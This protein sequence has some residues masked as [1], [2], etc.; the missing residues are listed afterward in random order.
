[1]INEIVA[2]HRPSI[3]VRDT[4][5]RRERHLRLPRAYA[6]AS[7]VVLTIAVA[8]IA[9]A[10]PSRWTPAQNV[11]ISVLQGS[12][13]GAHIAT[14]AGGLLVGPFGTPFEIAALGFDIGLKNTPASLVPPGSFSVNPNRPAAGSSGPYNCVY[15]FGTTVPKSNLIPGGI[16]DGFG[17]V[18]YIPFNPVDNV[19]SNLGQPA[20]YHPQADVTITVENPHLGVGLP[21][22]PEGRHTLN[23]SAATSMNYIMDVG[24]PGVLIPIFWYSENQLEAKLAAKAVAK[25]GKESAEL[26]AKKTAEN[27]FRVVSVAEEAG[28]IAADVSNVAS[29]NDWYQNTSVVTAINAGTQTLTVWDTH[30]PYFRD[31]QSAATGVT[32]QNIELEATDFGGVRFGR[33]ADALRARFEPVDDCGKQFQTWTDTQSSTLL[34]VG[35]GPTDVT[36]KAKEVDGGPY[37][38]SIQPASNQTR[39]GENFVTSLVQH[40][41]VVDTQ[42]PILVPP[43]GFARYSATSVDLNATPFPLGRPLVV[44][45]A[46]PAPVVTHTGPAVLD[47][48]HR[49]VIDWTATDDSGNST[50][51][52]PGNPSQYTQIVTIKSPG[53]NTP[54]TAAP[55]SAATLT[56]KAVEI[57]LTG[58]DSDLLDGR[59]DPLAFEIKDYP[60]HGQFEAPLLP[61]FIEDFRLSPVG[62]RENEQT[63]T[64]TSPLGDLAD[65]FRLEDPA[66]HGTFLTNQICNAAPG[67]ANEAAFNHTIPVNFVYQPTYIYVDDDGYYYIRDKFWVCGEPPNDGDYRTTM[68]PIPRISKWNAAGELVAMQPL[69]QTLSPLYDDPW[70]SGYPTDDFSVDH[71]GRIW[72]ELG[73]F[74]TAGGRIA[75]YYSF[76]KDLGDEQFHGTLGSNEQQLT[77]GEWL[78]KLA[79]DAQFDL[80]YELRRNPDC[81]F[82]SCEP[83][84]AQHSL[85]VRRASTAANLSTEDGVL[86]RI[87]LYGLGDKNTLGDLD[88]GAYDVKVDSHGNVYILDALKN[89]IHKYTATTR[90]DA[91]VWELGQEVGWMG[92]CSANLLDPNGVPYNG[93]DEAAQTSRGYQCTDA[94]C[95][96]AADTSGAGPG[97][98]NNP[99]SIEIDPR[100]VLYVA[101]TGNSR[102]QRFGPDGTFAGEAKSTGTGVNQGADPGF[103]LGNMGQ[104]K[105]LAV[106]SSAFYVMEPDPQNGDNFVHVFK[107]MP[108]YDITDASAK[109]K[110]VSQFDF[111]GTDGFTYVTNDGIDRSAP[112]AVSVDVSRAFRPPERLRSQCFADDTLTSEIPCTLAE[113]ADIVIRFSAYDPDGFISTGGLDSLTFNLLDQPQHGTLTLLTSED[114][115]AVY[116]YTPAADYN[117][118]DQLSFEASDGVDTSADN[119]SVALTIEPRPDPVAIEFPDN[120]V[121]ARGFQHTFT[122][123]FKDVDADDVSKPQALSVSWGDGVTAATPTWAGSGR[124]DTNGREIDPQQDLGIASG[125]IVGSHTYASTG[126]YA[127][128]ITMANAPAENLPDTVASTNVQVIEATVVG[129]SLAAPADPVAPD[130]PF[131]LQIDVTNYVPQGWAGLTAAGTQLAI[132]VPDGLTL[133]SLDNRCT[134]GQPIV[135]TIGDLTPGQ[136][137]TLTF[138]A[139][140]TLAAARADSDYMLKL[141]LTDAGPHAQDKNIGTATVSIADQDQDGVIDVDDAF[142]NDPRYS[143]DTDGDG[144]PDD[145]ETAHGFDPNTADNTALDSDGDGFTLAEEFANGSAPLLAEVQ[146]HKQGQKLESPTTGTNDR[147]GQALAGGDFNHDGYADT[148]IGA[149]LSDGPGAVFISYGSADGANPSLTSSKISAP[150]GVTFFGRALAVGDFDGNGYADLAIA[151]NEAI[152]I[153]LNNGQILETPDVVL[154]GAS[155]DSLGVFMT[156]GDLDGDG[157]ADL[158]DMAAQASGTGIVKIYLSSRGFAAAPLLFSSATATAADSAVIADIDGDQ[159]NDLVVGLSSIGTVN[160]FLARDNDWAN[161]ST[162]TT[163]FVLASP[164]P[165]TFGYSL[166]SGGDIGGDGIDDLVVGAYSGAGRIYVYDSTT[167]YWQTPN[168]GDTSTVPPSQTVNGLEDG[169]QPGDTFAGQFGVRIA[170]GKLD[171]DGYAD[172]VVGGS[173]AG[174]TDQGEVQIFHGGPT[175]LEPTPQI[176]PGATPYHMLGYFV[177]IPGDINGDGFDDVAAGAPDI[178]VSQNPAPTGGYVQTFYHAFVAADPNQDPDDD[179]VATAVDNCPSD[180]E[181]E[182]VRH[183]RR[184]RRRRVRL[185]RGRRRLRQRSRQLPARRIQRSDQQRR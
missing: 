148:V 163:S 162:L 109:V 20:V 93:C 139:L 124:L 31:T 46:D 32:Q 123:N 8:Q 47:P 137:A 121:A 87:D 58:T 152:S 138:G 69:Y 61:Y 25:V 77:S 115:A 62:D 92:S 86:G 60:P 184:R 94:T 166:A 53:T 12:L 14:V 175:G 88:L 136:S 180:R 128:Q 2:A 178:G 74:I 84:S 147:F 176:V 67:S 130:T 97:Q 21:E 65:A 18:F 3:A 100:D 140:I 150:A 43:P 117:G 107:T 181:H 99:R 146:T 29:A 156:A 42:A 151:G 103:I 118:S 45:L 82:V 51:A 28:L 78:L 125:M 95:A 142:P 160:A 39:D 165:S 5:Q 126:N 49:Y 101:D 144:L 36:W 23:W 154:T 141:E 106:N 104:P 27:I 9:A 22:F 16:Q 89:R 19:W 41:S 96:S 131:P 56:S 26:A 183:R 134:A 157:K 108:F 113:D 63:L 167:A 71:A 155:G 55:T 102:V 169:T 177:A 91:G 75:Q 80:Q 81:G 73:G 40:I 110:Y 161:A 15:K 52:P 122:A 66:N 4:Q 111:Q 1:M 149:P 114:N 179:G 76:D 72:I 173:R 30:V 171:T 185:R 34:K 127:L 54:P 132:T 153:H 135:C 11:G 38:S 85:V 112:A 98:F 79:G 119:K 159:K 129:S 10:D 120:L 37:P 6:F 133:A 116:R 158:V 24:L 143:V 68:S 172:V 48:D 90:N 164:G 7:G 50:V 83:A 17:S 145:W 64:R 59:V 105:Q 170:M 174:L 57:L 33:V 168:V 44:D 13:E 182:P 70:T 35:A